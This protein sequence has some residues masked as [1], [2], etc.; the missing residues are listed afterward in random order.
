METPRS[1]TSAFPDAAT[2]AAAEPGTSATLGIVR[3]RVKALQALAQA[4]AEG[5]LALPGGARCATLDAR[6]LPGIGEWTAQL[7]AMRAL[8]WPDAWPTT[9]IG[10]LNALGTRD[11]KPRGRK[12]RPGGPGAPMP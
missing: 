10:V 5:R 11:A 12:P 1:P 2:L 4:V 6:A 8:A 3:Q 7:I 9:D